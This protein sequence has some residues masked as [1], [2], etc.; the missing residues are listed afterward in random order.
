MKTLKAKPALAETIVDTSALQ[1][2]HLLGLL[3]VL[4]SLAGSILVPAAVSEELEA[5]LRLGK[6]LPSPSRFAWMRVVSP[7]EIPA[8]PRQDDLGPGETQVLALALE[9]PGAV[10]VLDDLIARRV[11]VALGIRR[12]GVLGILLQAKKAGLVPAITPLLDRVQGLGFRLSKT[13]RA[14]VLELAGE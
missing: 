13:T 7:S 2:L 14:E 6:D 11:A 4:K 8:L 5:G 12:T 9:H 1:Y 3:P 10:A